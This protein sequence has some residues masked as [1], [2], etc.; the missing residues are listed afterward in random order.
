LLCLVIVITNSGMN[1][2]L[3]VSALAAS[4]ALGCSSGAGH[5]GFVLPPADA[6]TESSMNEPTD[7]GPNADAAVVIRGHF[8]SYCDTVADC[9]P[10]EPPEGGS[11][12][13]GA[14]VVCVTASGRPL[15]PEY[16]FTPHQCVY[17][18]ATGWYIE[19]GIELEAGSN[20]PPYP[21]CPTACIPIH[22]TPD[23]ATVMDEETTTDPRVRDV[24]GTS[25]LC[26]PG[27]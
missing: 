3:L 11:I 13:Y 20:V 24:G 7:A 27:S 21:G 26:K 5:E 12:E 22:E 23:G 15:S 4:A 9:L 16:Y 25:W 17:T 14:I 19:A 18:C 6:D 1:I 8:G 10:F 2:R